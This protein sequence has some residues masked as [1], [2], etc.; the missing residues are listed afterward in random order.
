M[1]LR[2]EDRIHEFV[3][4]SRL[5]LLHVVGEPLGPD[6]AA[7]RVLD[8]TKAHGS[9][10]LASEAAPARSATPYKY[11]RVAQVSDDPGT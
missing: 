8:A 5:M 9:K 7:V 1:P 11:R 6:E 10:S 2:L 4:K 3:G